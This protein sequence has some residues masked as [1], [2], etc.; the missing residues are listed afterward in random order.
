MMIFQLLNLEATKNIN[1]I[2]LFESCN[3]KTKTV[4]RILKINLVIGHSGRWIPGSFRSN[5]GPGNF[6]LSSMGQQNAS[7]SRVQTVQ[8]LTE[9]PQE[10]SLQGKKVTNLLRNLGCF[11][12]WKE[13]DLKV[14]KPYIYIYNN[15]RYMQAWIFQGGFIEVDWTCATSEV[16]RDR[17]A[18]LLAR[19][20]KNTCWNGLIPRCTPPPQAL[21]SHWWRNTTRIAW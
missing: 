11:K 5:D 9:S 6:C 13:T 1:K 10:P 12:M 19:S 14:K 18:Y 3:G 20:K 7:W 2:Y 16:S 17:L 21:S 15:Y 4:S 8:G